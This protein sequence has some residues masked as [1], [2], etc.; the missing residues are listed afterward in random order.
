MIIMFDT[1]FIKIDI[2]NF[3][4]DI[5]TFFKNLFKLISKEKDITLD[6]IKKN[7]KVI[8][9][10]NISL[11][12]S[13]KFSDKKSKIPIKILNNLVIPIACTIL[14]EAKT[15]GG[16]RLIGN[17]YLIVDRFSADKKGEHIYLLYLSPNK[18]LFADED[19]IQINYEVGVD[20]YDHRIPGY[21][22]ASILNK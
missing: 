15:T 11:D 8:C 12:G 2:H 4:K 17:K 10:E 20:G 7:V 5:Y 18:V 14:I 13:G 16:F 3:L 9:E 19:P 6:D 22:R 21:F 1:N